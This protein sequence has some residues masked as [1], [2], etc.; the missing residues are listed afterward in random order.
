MT[1]QEFYLNNKSCYGGNLRNHRRKRI[2][3]RLSNK[4]FHHLVFKSN[5]DVNKASLRTP[6]TF[7]ISMHVIKVYAK[8]FR[9]RI[10]SHSI[11]KDHIHLLVR[12]NRKSNYQN[13]FR[14]VAGQIAQR[15][16][17]TYHCVKFK[18]NF[19][20]FRPFT[21]I[22]RNRRA[23]YIT[24]AYIRLNELE[25][26][27]VVPYQT[28]RLKKSTPKLWY[29]LKIDPKRAGWKFYTEIIDTIIT[30]PGSDRYPKLVS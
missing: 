15:V 3:R 24:K 6:K 14:V 19:W 20:K 7:S 4:R 27:K 8:R 29:Y 30:K 5:K 9:I 1:K 17:D 18:Q 13:F 28:S 12:T 25:G 26:R 21:R 10:A 16:T 2:A 23:Y 11:Q 22:V